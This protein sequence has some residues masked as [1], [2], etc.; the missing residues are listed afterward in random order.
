MADL[1]T[2]TEKGI[3]TLHLAGRIDSGNAAA[4]EELLSASAA[5][6]VVLDLDELEY[7]SSAG[8]R[9]ILRFYRK[10]KEMRIVNARP[11]IWNIFEMTGF[12]SLMPI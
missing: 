3:C 11:E 4:V 7:L 8:L 2:S 12:T 9:V 1:K 5:D 10:H 6:P